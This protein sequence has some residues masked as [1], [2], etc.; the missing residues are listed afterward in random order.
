[1]LI[2]AQ[3]DVHAGGGKFG[4]AL[5]LAVCKG[6]LLL[7]DMLIKRDADCTRVNSIEETPLH[8]L[9]QVY[10]KQSKFK[11]IAEC[12]VLAAADPNA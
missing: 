5:H 12:L 3:V 4:S 9:F 7:T 6:D 1:M 11:A 8:Q 10:K 2:E